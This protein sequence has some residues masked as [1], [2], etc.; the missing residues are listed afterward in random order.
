M[1]LKI[2]L[3]K[4]LEELYG[5]PNYLE[6]DEDRYDFS[7]PP[8]KMDQETLEAFIKWNH[9]IIVG[10]ETILLFPDAT[11]ETLKFAKPLIED[12]KADMEEAK[13]FLKAN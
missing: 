10:L 3:P 13:K 5:K 4:E 1:D 7:I 2:Q 6:V 11:D 12:C 9:N 8:K